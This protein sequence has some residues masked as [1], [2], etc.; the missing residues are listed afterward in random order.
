[1]PELPVL[2]AAG[3]QLN[4]L[5]FWAQ[6]DIDTAFYDA[7]AITIQPD[8]SLFVLLVIEH[9]PTGVITR[10]EATAFE[11]FALVMFARAAPRAGDPRRPRAVPAE[12]LA[13]LRADFPWLTEDDVRA[14]SGRAAG[15]GGGGGMEG[16]RDAI[17]ERLDPD[18]FDERAYERVMD[19]LEKVRLEWAFDDETVTENFYTHQAGGQWTARFR[20]ALADVADMKAR[21]HVHGFC[22]M[23]QWPRMKRFHYSAHGELGANRLAQEWARKGDFFYR[24]WVDSAGAETFADKEAHVYVESLELLEWAVEVD[25]DS[26]TWGKIS[27]LKAAFPQL[28]G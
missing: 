27:E 25:V 16:E 14:A 11:A 13:R 26:H 2:E 22:T 24:K 17:V 4:P 19:E 7:T 9:V 8:D 10:S 23:F 12:L 3:A 20:G 5:L 15:A 21:A 1:M 6:Y 28:V 18:D